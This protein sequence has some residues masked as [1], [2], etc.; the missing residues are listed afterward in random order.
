M[1]SPFFYPVTL[2]R[3]T[4][5][6]PVSASWVSSLPLV[7]SIVDSVFVLTSN[8]GL[9]QGVYVWDGNR[10]RYCL[11]YAEICAAIIGGAQVDI[12]YHVDDPS[13]HIPTNTLVWRNGLPYSQTTFTLNDDAVWALLA[14][15]ASAVGDVKSIN[16]QPPNAAGNVTLSTEN[17]TGTGNGIVVDDGVNSGTVTLKTFIADVGVSI[18][19]STS[20]L[21]IKNTGVLTVNGQAPVNGAVSVIAQNANAVTGQ[22]LIVDS[23]ATTGVITFKTIVAGQN[24][25]LSTDTNGNLKIDGSASYVLPAATSTTLGG[26]KIGSGVNVTADGTISIPPFV[27]PIASSTVLG[28]VKIGANISVAGDGT[29]SVA[30]APVSSVSGQTGVVVVKTTDNNPATGVTLIMDTGATTGNA[31]LKTLVAGSNVSLSS[32]AS[33][34]LRIDAVAPV[35]SV[36][37]QT[38][39][40]VVQA[41]DNNSSTGQSLIVD[42]GATTGISKFRTIAAGANITISLDSYGNMVVN[43]QAGNTGTVSSVALAM[44]SIFQVSGSPVTTTGTLTA[45]LLGQNANMIFAGPVSG[46]ANVPTFRALVAAD[47][48][49]ATSTT[50]GAIIPGTGLSVAVNGVLSLN[51][52]QVVTSVAGRTGAITLSVS[53]VSGAAPLNSPALTGTPTSTTPP[54]ADNSTRVATTAFVQSLISAGAVLSFNSRTGAVTL[55]ASDVSGVGGAL[56]GAANTYTDVNDFTAGAAKVATLATT[57][58]STNAASTAFVHNLFSGYA[59]L[60]SPA[61][62]GVP[63]APTAATGTNTT[64][65][66]TT[67]FVIAQMATQGGVTS[68][69]SRAG[70]VTLIASDVSGV[71][72]ALVGS[73]NTWTASNDFTGGTVTVATQLAADN[74]TKAASTAFVHTLLSTAAVVSFNG[75]TGAV[76]LAGS[77]V[78]GAGGALVGSANTWTAANDFTA[79]TV[80]VATQLTSD[81]STNAASTAFVQAVVTAI[82][83]QPAS[84]TVLGGVKIPA[85]VTSGLTVQT[86]GT[87]TANVVTVAGRGGNVVLSVGDVSGAAPLVSPALTGVPTTP[88]AAAGTN[89]TQIASTA[90]VVE[91][92]QSEVSVALA[93]G[94]NTLAT[95]DAAHAVIKLTGALTAN[96]TLTVPVPGNWIFYNNTTGAFTVTLS[97]GAGS[98]FVLQQ[99]G[100]AHLFSDSALGV[101]PA[102]ST[103]VTTP[104]NDNSSSIATTAYVQNVLGT[105]GNVVNS[106]NTRTGAVTLRTSDVS[107]VG[108]AI[109]SAANT[110]TAAN[111]F[112]GGSIAVATA[113]VGDSTTKAASTAFVSTAMLGTTTVPLTNA[114]VT[115]TAAQYGKQIIEFTGNLTASVTITVPTSGLWT[116]YNNTTGAFN[117]TLSNGAGSTYVVTQSQSA[118]AVSLGSLGVINSNVAVYTL[119]PAT[120]AVLGG[121]IVPNG[122]GLAINAQGDLSVDATQIPYLSN[123]AFTGPVTLQTP[124]A[125][126]ANDLHAATTTFAYQVG[127]GIERINLDGL[128]NAN[129]FALTLEQARFPVIEFYGTP[130]GNVVITFPA[131]GKWWIFANTA[132]RPPIIASASGTQVTLTIG[133]WY[134][135]VAD[136]AASSALILLSQSTGS[137]PA[138]VTSFNTRTGA[139]TLQASDVSGVGGALVGGANTF[140]STND[141]TGGTITVATQST[142]DN[143]TKAASTAFVK[144]VLGT[145]APLASPTFTGTPAAPTATAGT[146]TTQLATTAYVENAVF[147][148]SS[149]PIGST[150]VVLTTTQ[151]GTQIIKLTGTLTAN[152][153][154]SF[155]SQVGEWNVYNATSGAFSLTAISSTGAATVVLA[156]GAVTSLIND[157]SAGILSSTVAAAGVTSF[158]SRTGAVTL[159]GS[160][161][162]GAG[163]ALVG[164]ANTWTAANSFTGGSITVPT[165]TTGDNTTNAANTAFVYSTMLAEASL[166][167]SNANISANGWNNAARVLILTGTLTGN[168]QVQFPSSGSWRVFNNTSGAFTVQAYYTGGQPNVTL[169]QGAWTSIVSLGA[170]S[171]GVVS[172]N[173]PS[174]ASFNGRTG[175]VTLQASDVS[176]VGGVLTSANNTYSAATTQ[177]FTSATITVATQTASDN[178]TKA[179]STAYV[180]TKLSSSPTIGTPTITGRAQIDVDTF[181]VQQVSTA[182]T[183]TLD[184]S[185]YGEFVVTISGATTINLTNPPSANYGQ[186][187]IIHMTNGGSGTISWQAGGSS[188]TPKYANGAAPTYTATGTD[189]IAVLVEYVG[190]ATTYTVVVIAQA[191]A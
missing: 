110:Y 53:D 61:F 105:G 99:N 151:M 42:S 64:Q 127:Q 80:K 190:S 104:A 22:S 48:P 147:G 141:F 15:P 98:S 2:H 55:L 96:A 12:Y 39:A 62:T 162:S 126:T 78:S 69:N 102:V 184:L 33:N 85:P 75:R 46:S 10:F 171:G 79:G 169:P 37:G 3:N 97:N 150:A 113:A 25:A 111:D 16:K 94:A 87:L 88:T 91:Q 65:I 95:A 63:T 8:D 23:G 152:S 164:S 21:T 6:G 44:P 89:T 76:T 144:S 54:S 5:A 120:T 138:G 35:T 107:G 154:V 74:S 86:D 41:K 124:P 167:L 29:I 1:D 52:S 56:V 161:I 186:V 108:G 140:T 100:S 115:L 130:S 101:T 182:S 28:G 40:V 68:F 177:D 83:L 66:A 9:A 30:P 188:I 31:K 82:A 189:I 109:V 71:G 60:A 49:F 128:A 149:V 137:G 155:G 146:N 142:A 43:G 125:Y 168:V 135:Y 136:S 32:D 132:T 173:P 11:P 38:G 157:V 160:D 129:S 70:A 178:S 165:Q 27:L 163:G 17:A 114:N 103:A 174:V 36:S 81:N 45:V 143:S 116:F 24:I 158:N 4:I 67:A 51:T 59:L 183:I 117:V 185:L 84:A 170:S 176:G 72:G 179:A 18:T 13:L 153:T 26:V 148:E 181:K 14:Y 106:F 50:A 166:T 156:Q 58:N 118:Q 20:S 131:N 57:D 159:Q 47:L 92:M 112:T 90:F 119:Q 34:N 145:Y 133:N 180:T 73:A 175:A 187:A 139:V 121:V 93:N 172:A 19:P 191:V 123:A 134:E 7:S 122:G 77:D